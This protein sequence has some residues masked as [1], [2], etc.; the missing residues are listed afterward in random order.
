MLNVLKCTNVLIKLQK[1]A[2]K[3]KQIKGKY[4]IGLENTLSK[5]EMAAN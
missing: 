3:E 4:K 2:R 1:K 5:N